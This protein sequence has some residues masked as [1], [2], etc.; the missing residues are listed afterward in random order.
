MQHLGLR[1]TSWYITCFLDRSIPFQKLYPQICNNS[2]SSWVK[3]PCLIVL[4]VLLISSNLLLSFLATL[5]YYPFRRGYFTRE[6]RF[7]CTG[8]SFGKYLYLSRNCSEV[9]CK[10]IL[11]DL[12]SVVVSSTPFNLSRHC[13]KNGIS[14]AKQGQCMTLDFSA[15]HFPSKTIGLSSHH[16][17]APRDLESNTF[18]VFSF[19]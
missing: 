2:A 3:E 6:K 9:Y 13:N 19:V 5:W 17:F 10:T 14:F 18:W 7:C 12:L 8:Y 11:W 4:D 15:S 16:Y 1:L